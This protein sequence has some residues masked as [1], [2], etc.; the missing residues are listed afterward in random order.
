MASALEQHEHCGL[1]RA[2]AIGVM[3]CV[4]LP[5]LGVM[6]HT[7]GNSCLQL[8][9]LLN[10]LVV[11][12]II[13]WQACDPFA[14]AAQWIGNQLRLPGSVRGA[15]LDAVASSMPELLSGVFFILLVAAH[16]GTRG[17][18]NSE[19][20]GE[21]IGATIATCAGSAIYNVVL[22]PAICTLFI[23]YY[24]RERPTIDLERQVLS[25]D[26]T[27]F[28]YCEIILI[29][30]LFQPTLHW[31]MA[32]VLLG[33][34]LVYLIKLYDAAKRHRGKTS[35]QIS[36]YDANDDRATATAFFGRFEVPLNAQTAWGTICVSTIIAAVACYWLVEVTC[37]AAELL[38]VPLFFVAVILA[39]A[40]SSVPDT[41]LSVGAARRGD[42]DGA[43]S[44]AFGSNIFD[45]CVCLAIPLLLAS[46]LNGWRPIELTVNGQPLPGLLG[47]RVLLCL[48]T[49]ITLAMMW[50]RQQLTR[51][52]AWVL[53]G[54]YGLFVA[55]AVI[56]S[57]H[58]AG[59]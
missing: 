24:R 20:C 42:D 2:F 10:Q 50:H 46:Y 48:M 12:S 36:N 51:T 7:T 43:V 47:L 16:G 9:F 39:A 6:A 28:L 3:S 53:C 15:T 30:F 34:Y 14:D 11:I 49:A 19:A 32:V 33:L 4:A 22:I 1:R 31:W 37:G 59:S 55:F 8:L 41:L 21:G 35:N 5:I 29:L 17:C 26:G 18:L 45:I 40:A 58:W 27:W 13:I 56:G 23:S 25:R 38:H 57:V 44:N 52:K 54:M